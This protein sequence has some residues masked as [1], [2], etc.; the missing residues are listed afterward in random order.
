MAGTVSEPDATP[1][2]ANP[3]TSFKNSDLPSISARDNVFHFSFLTSSYAL[4]CA[5][6]WLTCEFY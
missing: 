1:P 6:R 3:R 2:L 5:Y 4:P